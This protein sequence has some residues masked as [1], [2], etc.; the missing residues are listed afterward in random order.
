MFSAFELPFRTFECTFKTFERRFP[1]VAKAFSTGR[2]S[3]YI[4]YRQKINAQLGKYFSLTGEI[5]FAHYR[6]RMPL[7]ERHSFSMVYAM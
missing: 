5:F 1:P 2:R 4:L 6:R 7:F 3:C